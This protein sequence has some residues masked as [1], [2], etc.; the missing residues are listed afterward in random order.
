MLFFEIV[1]YVTD[2]LNDLIIDLTTY[3]II[4]TKF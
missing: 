1:Y 4:S 3:T 2:T